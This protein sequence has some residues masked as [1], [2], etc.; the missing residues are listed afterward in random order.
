MQTPDLA[1]FES[2]LK[3]K[4]HN[5]IESVVQLYDIVCAVVA[6]DSIKDVI[7]YLHDEQGYTFLTTMNG[8]HFPHAVEKFG[9]VYHLHNLPQNLRVRLK[10]FSASEHPVFPSIMDIFPGANWMEREAYDFFGFHFTGHKNLK[11][12]LNMDSMEGWPMRK[13]YPIEDQARFDKDDKMFGR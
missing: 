13:E 7:K 6:L 8:M 11:R 9:M 1:T 12:I 10:T 5:K 3:E 2:Q 4:F